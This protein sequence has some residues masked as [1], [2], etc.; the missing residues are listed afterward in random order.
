MGPAEEETLEDAHC[1]THRPIEQES[2]NNQSCPPKWVTLD[3]SEVRQEPWTELFLFFSCWPMTPSCARLHSTVHAQVRPRF[4][5]PHRLVQEQR[6]D[7][8]LPSRPLPEPHQTPGPHPLQLRPLPASTLDP[9]RMGTGKTALITSLRNKIL[10]NFAHPSCQH[11]MESLGVFLFFYP[12]LQNATSFKL[13]AP[14]EDIGDN[15]F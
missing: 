15:N 9:R 3:W 13:S 1:L 8:D 2:C 11:P 10:T 6:P 4:Q 12:V 5:A 7:K 14:E